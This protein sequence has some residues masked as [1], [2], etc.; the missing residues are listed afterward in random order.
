M[1]LHDRCETCRLWND[2]VRSGQ[3]G[4][5]NH[6]D[7]VK[8]RERGQTTDFRWANDYCKHWIHKSGIAEL[9]RST[10]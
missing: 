6:A 7:Q 5:C 9:N 2:D 8:A 3:V 10:Q 4:H 1:S